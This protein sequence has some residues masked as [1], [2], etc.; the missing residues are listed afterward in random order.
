MLST[1]MFLS[2]QVLGA[3]PSGAELAHQGEEV[4]GFGALL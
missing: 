3:E 2:Y 1:P 4:E